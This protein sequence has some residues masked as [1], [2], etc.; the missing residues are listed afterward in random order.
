MTNCPLTWAH[1][2]P[3]SDSMR[4]SLTPSGGHVAHGDIKGHTALT[5]SPLMPR[6]AGNGSLTSRAQPLTQE[7]PRLPAGALT[8]HMAWR[9]HFKNIHRVARL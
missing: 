5:Q 4:P 8:T 3:D 7:E 1:L 2:L 9:G 6:R